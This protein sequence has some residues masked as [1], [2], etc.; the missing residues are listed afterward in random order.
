MTLTLLV[1]SHLG[2]VMYGNSR[3]MVLVI[4][5]KIMGIYI[6]IF[7]PFLTPDM[8]MTAVI[9]WHQKAVITH[10]QLMV[11]IHPQQ[12]IDIQTM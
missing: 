11:V 5:Q 4:C 9:T 6:R 10:H 8:M 12:M 3:M 2:T 1:N 7:E